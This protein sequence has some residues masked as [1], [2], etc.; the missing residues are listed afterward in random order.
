MLPFTWLPKNVDAVFLMAC[1]LLHRDAGLWFRWERLGWVKGRGSYR[2]VAFWCICQ[3]LQATCFSVS[4]WGQD[5]PASEPT[6]MGNRTHCVPTPLT[7]HSPS[8]C[9]PGCPQKGEPVRKRGGAW[10]GGSRGRGW[11]LIGT[12]FLWDAGTRAEA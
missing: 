3:L 1:S 9:G 6:G 7:S 12:C 2:D 4:C 11:R 5:L 8:T 10:C